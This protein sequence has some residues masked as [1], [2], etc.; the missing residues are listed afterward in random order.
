MSV[1]PPRRRATAASPPGHYARTAA[2][3]Q[4]LQRRGQQPRVLIIACCDSRVD[5][6]TITDADPGTLFV[7]RNVANLVPACT[8]GGA[9]LGTAAAVEFAVGHL[10]VRDIVIMG[11]ADCGGARALLEHGAGAPATDDPVGAWMAL[12]APARERVRAL[13]VAQA[14]RQRAL[15]EEIIR[16]G[17]RNLRT[18]RSVREAVSE[19]RLTLHGWH[20]D[21]A[22][23]LLN[24]LDA[25]TDSFE[26]LL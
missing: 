22:A 6:V 16:L 9:H 10:Q 11:H 15:E 23:G 25:L 3:Y 18:H 2:L 19:G 26:P 8:P 24:A 12:A 5:P 14:G 7:V 17:L 4:R 13:D 20:F 1:A 21:M